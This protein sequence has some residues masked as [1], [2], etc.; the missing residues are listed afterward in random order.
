VNIARLHPWWR[1][2]AA[3]EKLLI[4][5]VVLLALLGLGDALITGPLAKRAQ[6]AETEARALR[7][8][9]DGVRETERADAERHRTLRAQEAALRERLRSAEADAAALRRRA[10]EAARLPETLR[11]ITAT[12]GSVKLNE[13]DLSGDTGAAG[14][15]APGAAAGQ[16]LYRL[17]ITLKVSGSYAELHALLTQIERHADALLWQSVALDSKAWPEIELTL[18]AHVLSADPRWGAN[19]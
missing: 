11:A 13:L 19:P 7:S 8:Q 14:A 17:P 18:K 3:R 6:R 1:A 2:R 9:L 15:S 16:R 4:G 10:A 5:G 12:V